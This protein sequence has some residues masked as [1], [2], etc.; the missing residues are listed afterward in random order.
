MRYGATPFSLP[1]A[2]WRALSELGIQPVPWDRPSIGNDEVVL[3][4]DSPDQ[5]IA[6]LSLSDSVQEWKFRN[7]VQ[8]Y[9]S[10]MARSQ[11]TQEP[12][13][14]ISCLLMHGHRW[15]ANA[16]SSENIIPDVLPAPLDAAPGVSPELAAC[17]LSLIEAEPELLDG[18]HDLELRAELQGREPDV[19]YRGRLQQVASNG[20]A[21]ILAYLAS[22][23]LLASSR[24]QEQRL[25]EL[26]E[27]LTGKETAVHEARE[28]AETTRVQLHKLK[29]ELESERQAFDKRLIALQECVADKDTALQEA[30]QEIELTQMQLHQVQEELEQYFFRSRTADQLARIQLDLLRRAQSLLRRMDP[31]LPLITPEVIAINAEATTRDT[32]VERHKGYQNADA[33]LN[34]YAA[35]LER[36]KGLLERAKPN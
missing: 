6:I 35:S 11:Q 18:Y 24:E 13:F 33:L 22:Q 20:D 21:L 36:A 14:R 19:K 31:T 7:L 32:Q 8:G 17:V 29:E 15:P 5:L 4:Y 30:R 28:E 16:S 26:Q 23:Q 27:C 3:L 1:G 34:A 10:L 12:L 2:T 9:R 25:A